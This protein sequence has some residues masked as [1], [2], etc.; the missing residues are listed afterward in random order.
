MMKAAGVDAATLA[1]LD[2]NQ[3]TEEFAKVAG[4]LSIDAAGKDGVGQLV[5]ADQFGLIYY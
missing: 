1:N 5:K 3:R 4:K 2:W